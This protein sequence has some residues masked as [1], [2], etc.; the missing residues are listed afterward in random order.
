MK[1]LARELRAE[2]KDLARELRADH[3]TL[4]A[5]LADVRE[6]LA[7]IEGRL[8]IGMKKRTETET[9]SPE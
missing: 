8:G 7:R 2:M 4:R 9:D 3:A 6:R 5:S 1:D